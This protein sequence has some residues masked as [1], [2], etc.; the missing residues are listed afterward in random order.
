MALGSRWLDG[1]VVTA[2]GTGINLAL[3]VLYAWSVIKGGIPDSWGWTHADKALPYAVACMVF[4]VAMVVAGR[5]QDRYGPSMVAMVGG[6]LVGVGCMLAGLTAP[7][8][9]GFVLGFGCLAGLGIGFGYAAVTP[10]AI[11]WFPPQRTGLVTGI[12]VAGFGLAPVIIAPL[13]TWMLTRYATTTDAGV[14]EKGVGPTMVV[15]GS[16]VLAVVALMAQLL[17]NPPEGHQLPVARGNAAAAKKGPDMSWRQVLGTG[18]FYLLWGMYFCGAASGLTFISV[19]QDLGKRSLGEWAFLAVVV[20]AIGNATGRIVAGTV[21][22]RLGRQWTMFVEFVLQA[23]VVLALYGVGRAAGDGGTGAGF[24]A[25]TL[26]VVMFLGANYGANLALFPAAA[27]DAW[28]LKGFGLNYGLLFTAWGTA[29]M[30]MPWVN[31]RIQDLTGNQDLTYAII[32]GMMF[33][34]AGL[35]FPSRAMAARAA[36][37]AQAQRATP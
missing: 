31:G 6:G 35:T 27:K 34:A 32:I 14:V 1:K 11:K 18:Q 3:G 13:A 33:V 19:A 2:A 36:A 30:V 5:L 28:G 17:R 37:N 9:A 4:S 7:S 10:A 21:S 23:L 16:A 25:A 29:G 26:G 15:F 24:V 12:V 8:L 20:L 22:D